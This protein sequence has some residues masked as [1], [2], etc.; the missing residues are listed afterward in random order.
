MRSVPPDEPESTQARIRRRSRRAAAIAVAP[1]ALQVLRVVTDG[2]S[3]LALA[4]TVG[5]IALMLP[6]LLY[7]GSRVDE[8]LRAKHPDALYVGRSNV[9][10]E[11]VVHA[12]ETGAA[13]AG[14]RVG[15]V[16]FWTQ[17]QG[18]M[19]GTLRL[20]RTSL[21]WSPLSWSRRFKM[22]EFEI[23]LGHIIS[24]ESNAAVPAL[25]RAGVVTA[26]LTSGGTLD[27]TVV[28]RDRFA[29]AWTRA[30]PPQV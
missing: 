19:S 11:Q 4:A 17:S 12:G 21:Q 24:L 9:Y 5:G 15:R 3:W 22:E 1:L 2:G 14:V 27:F 30:R 18:A 10:A 16:R 6:V 28:D 8:R 23:P 7:V 29:D 20:S 25:G 26:H 13:A